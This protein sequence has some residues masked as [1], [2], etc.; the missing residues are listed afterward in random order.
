MSLPKTRA[1]I[2]TVP[3]FLRDIITT[4]RSVGAA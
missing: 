2:V 1:I 3:T 4:L